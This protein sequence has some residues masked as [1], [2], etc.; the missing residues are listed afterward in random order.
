MRFYLGKSGDPTH[1]REAKEEENYLKTIELFFLGQHQK[2][3]LANSLR[4]A[5]RRGSDGSTK[6]NKLSR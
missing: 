3:A 6:A 1:N 4:A 5:L 2:S